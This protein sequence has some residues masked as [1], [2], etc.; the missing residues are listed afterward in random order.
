MSYLQG[1]VV[2]RKEYLKKKEHFF[3]R[4]NEL[5]VKERFAI[6]VDGRVIDSLC[7]LV[8]DYPYRAIGAIGKRRNKYVY[9][10]SKEEFITGENGNNNQKCN[11]SINNG[12]IIFRNNTS[13]IWYD[14]LKTQRTI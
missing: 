13:V 14:I 5:G 8:D 10:V 7:E 3:R 2:S 4:K 9:S 6:K 12:K 1:E 11:F